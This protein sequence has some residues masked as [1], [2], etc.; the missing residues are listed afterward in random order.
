MLNGKLG[1]AF[2]NARTVYETYRSAPP[3]SESSAKYAGET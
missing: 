3:I 2:L 1:E